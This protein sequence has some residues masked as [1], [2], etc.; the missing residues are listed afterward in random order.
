MFE[1]CY[2]QCYTS[3][4]TLL[5]KF[6]LQI[7]NIDTNITNRLSTSQQYCY[8]IYDVLCM[9]NTFVRHLCLSIEMMARFRGTKLN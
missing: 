7:G 2:T 3:A 6:L 4:N 5:N 8:T 9:Y 1:N